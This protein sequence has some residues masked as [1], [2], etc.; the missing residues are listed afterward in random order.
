MKISHHF[1][2]LAHYF[3]RLSYI[4][5]LHH[6]FFFPITFAEMSFHITGM[7]GFISEEDVWLNPHTPVQQVEIF[8]APW[9]LVIR[10]TTEET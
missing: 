5:G 2:M 7:I 4:N 6:V 8:A 3:E 10:H 1:E 9:L